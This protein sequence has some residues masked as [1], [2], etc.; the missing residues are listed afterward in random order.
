MTKKTLV[1]N[2]NPKGRGK[3]KAKVAKAGKAVK[4]AK[5]AKAARRNK[6]CSRLSKGRLTILIAEV[7]SIVKGLKGGLSGGG[8]MS[9]FGRKTNAT[10]KNPE[11]SPEPVPAAFTSI[12]SANFEAAARVNKFPI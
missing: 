4:T 7:D 10:D 1:P 6:L 11:A 12:A 5:A 2:K 8:I 9:L 3:G